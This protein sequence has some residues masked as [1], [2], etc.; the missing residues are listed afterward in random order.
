MEK[1][2]MVPMISKAGDSSSVPRMSVERVRDAR[3]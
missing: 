3:G 2:K 1:V